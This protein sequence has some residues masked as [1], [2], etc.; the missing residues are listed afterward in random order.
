MPPKT[1]CASLAPCLWALKEI[2]ERGGNGLELARR[3]FACIPVSLNSIA[4]V[5]RSAFEH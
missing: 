2:L 5:S 4:A 3:C 1:T